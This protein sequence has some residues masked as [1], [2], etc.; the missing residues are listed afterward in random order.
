MWEP[1]LAVA[2]AAGGDWP[3]RAREAAVA[4]VALSLKSTPSLG[5]RLLSDL[6]DIFSAP[7]FMSEDRLATEVLLK[8]LVAV[9]ES[10]WGDLRGKPLDSR[11]LA[12]M[13][14]KYEIHSKNMRGKDGT[15]VMKGYDRAD[16]ADAWSR[17][18]GPSTPGSAT[19][20]TGATEPNDTPNSNGP[21]ETKFGRMTN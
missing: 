9:P 13:L 5:I 19:D 3:R 15:S 10:P 16:L 8:C 17:Y 1:L 11:G 6:R 7:G 2:D 20:A 21:R 18:L 14:R 12:R 4:L